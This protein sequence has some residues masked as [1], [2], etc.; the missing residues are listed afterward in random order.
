MQ[1][2]MW[3]PSASAKV[4]RYREGWGFLA[5]MLFLLAFVGLF[6]AV[7]LSPDEIVTRKGRDA[8]PYIGW[9]FTV[10]FGPLALIGVVGAIGMV[11]QLH[12]LLIDERGIWLRIHG[13]DRSGLVERIA[14]DPR[15]APA[16][17]GQRRPELETGLR[18]SAVPAGR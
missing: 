13:R 12:R 2:E 17:Q 5:G 7:A 4:V 18:G 9:F 6:L 15:S 1:T 16:P 8:A 11:A 14:R 3:A 10:L